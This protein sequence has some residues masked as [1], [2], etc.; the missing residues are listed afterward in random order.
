MQITIYFIK[1][2]N[3]LK[4]IVN[5]IQTENISIKYVPPEAQVADMFTKHFLIG[6]FTG[7]FNNLS[8]IDIY[9]PA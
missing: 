9:T 7:Y 4:W 2:L 3:T 5:P 1:E 8:M 6:D